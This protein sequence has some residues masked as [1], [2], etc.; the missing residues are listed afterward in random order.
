MLFALAT[1]A[2]ARAVMVLLRDTGAFFGSRGGE[3]DEVCPRDCAHEWRQDDVRRV[4]VHLDSPD[5]AKVLRVGVVCPPHDDGGEFVRGWADSEGEGESDV[6]D[7]R[8]AERHPLA[9]IR[10][11]ALKRFET[12]AD[13]AQESDGGEH[14]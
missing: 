2:G 1:A 12:H 3:V 9:W 4:R 6:V 11:E 5:A 10:P 8:A 14:T 13:L 7:V